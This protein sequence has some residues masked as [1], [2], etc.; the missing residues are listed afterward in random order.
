MPVERTE[1]GDIIFLARAPG[2]VADNSIA[3]TGAS[4]NRGAQSGNP[5]ADPGSGRFAPKG[6]VDVPAAINQNPVAVSR[7]GL[8]QGTTV[9]TWEKRLD[10]VRDAAREF[11]A[12]DA[13]DAQD[14]LNGRVQDLSQVNVD[15]FLVDV[16]AHRLD[17]L[18]DILDT[19]LRT[20]VAGMLR[21]RR[22]VR[23]NAPKG[24][25]NRVFAGLTDPEIQRVVTRLTDRGWKSADL[26]KYIISRVKD[27]GR[28]QSLEQAI[29]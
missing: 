6:N 23:V 24:W 9:E 14:F 29:G 15:Q 8:P 22:Y 12:M 10:A 13:G 3:N 1:N 21:S 11:D 25:T 2:Q 19:Q 20:K 7:S 26:K 4:V 17:D 27:E 5:N 18:V 16:R 28:R